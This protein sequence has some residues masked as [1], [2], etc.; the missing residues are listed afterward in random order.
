[1]SQYSIL[2]VDDHT[3]VRKGLLS[4]INESENYQVSCETDNG[5]EAIKMAS[6]CKPDI[7]LMD[8]SMPELNGLEATRQIKKNNPKT[9][10]IILTRHINEEYIFEVIS[11]GASGYIVK[12]AA[13]E[14]LIFAMEAVTRGETYFSP[15][16]S[17]IISDKI[18]EGDTID[19]DDTYSSF[20]AREREV[21]Q[22]IAE[23]Y[24]TKKIANKL[25]ISSKTVS[26]HR[27]NIKDK[28]DL[29]STA[30][31]TKYAIKHGLTDIDI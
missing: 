21:L 15:S 7:V 19:S 26:N 10:I 8:I 25:Y 17:T 5:R 22:L 24:T 2:L 23:G 4:L 11:I 31:L 27:S 29:H 3:I 12:K 20:T 9:K 6:E 18:H 30:E 28:L 13:P 16:V 1:M 14:E